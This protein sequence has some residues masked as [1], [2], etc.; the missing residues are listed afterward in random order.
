MNLVG[1]CEGLVV[2]RPLTPPPRVLKQNW[3]WIFFCM[4]LFFGCVVRKYVYVTQ[5]L[6]YNS[7]DP[8]RHLHNRIHIRT[9]RIPNHTNNIPPRP[10]QLARSGRNRHRAPQTHR[11]QNRPPNEPVHGE[12][13]RLPHA[14]DDRVLQQ[15]PQLLLG[16]RVHALPVRRAVHGA[17]RDVLAAP[18]DELFVHPVVYGVGGADVACVW[19]WG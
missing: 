15:P 5:F 9:I 13:A 6:N 1:F 8:L 3:V 10:T 2:C 18:A 17:V 16:L 7:C 11:D 12:L 14:L 4:S 19:R